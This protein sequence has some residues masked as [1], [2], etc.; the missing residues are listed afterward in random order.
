M[1]KKVK[2]KVG[3][4]K[5]KKKVKKNQV[6]PMETMY[7]TDEDI[8]ES[9]NVQEFLQKKGFSWPFSFGKKKGAKKGGKKKGKKK[10]K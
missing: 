8:W 4:K 1:A 2:K 7:S 3:K 6:A 5:G 9:H 10:R